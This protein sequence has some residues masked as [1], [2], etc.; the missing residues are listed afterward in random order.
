[1]LG[2]LLT[3]V[4]V[5]VAVRPQPLYWTEG[6][7][8]LVAP[9]GSLQQAPDSYWRGN[10]I[11]FAGVL[12]RELNGAAPPPRMNSAPIYGTG[13]RDGSSVRLRNYGNQWTT[14]FAQPNLTVEVVGPDEAGVARRYDEV[15]TQVSE[16]ARALQLT[17]GTRTQ[18]LMTVQ[19]LLGDP[20]VAYVGS[21]R[22]G[23]ARAVLA[24]G[25]VG[26]FVSVSGAV[27][28]D[29][30]AR[31]R[32]LRRAAALAPALDGAPVAGPDPRAPLVPTA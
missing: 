8:V 5:L 9:G 13:V 2:L 19:P 1:V 32:R 10:L 22:G 3:A 27:L 12:D 11:A 14:M 31:R 4:A 24:I 21:T 30:R 28:L 29:E 15:V 16:T 25:L 20:P 6:D 26:S 17:Q 18:D 7:V 23:K